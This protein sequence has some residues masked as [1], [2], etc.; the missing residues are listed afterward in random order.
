MIAGAA[1]PKI[2]DVEKL[3]KFLLTSIE[4]PAIFVAIGDKVRQFVLFNES[5]EIICLPL[6]KSDLFIQKK[7][8]IIF[9]TM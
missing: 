3:G 4:I 1:D 2:F 7:L 9:V 6:R 8:F 5:T